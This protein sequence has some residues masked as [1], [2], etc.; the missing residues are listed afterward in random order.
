MK[1]GK[2]VAGVDSIRSVYVTIMIFFAVKVGVLFFRFANI[3]DLKGCGSLIWQLMNTVGV[4]RRLSLIVPRRDWLL[5]PVSVL[6]LRMLS[7]LDC[8]NWKFYFVM[9]EYNVPE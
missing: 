4:R 7:Q 1:F 5:L 8:I 9:G 3:A 2:I 6:R